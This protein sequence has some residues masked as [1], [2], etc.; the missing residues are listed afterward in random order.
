MATFSSRF[1]FSATASSRRVSPDCGTVRGE[2][3]G[4]RAYLIQLMQQVTVGSHEGLELQHSIVVHVMGCLLEQR[5]KFSASFREPKLQRQSLERDSVEGPE[6]TLHLQQP[7]ALETLLGN[8][9]APPKRRRGGGLGVKAD[10][11]VGVIEI[12]DRPTPRRCGPNPS[13]S[14]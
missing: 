11:D 6:A 1:E 2:S 5:N 3:G 4:V 12:K 9:I 7:Q 14:N 13:V 10:G 8:Q